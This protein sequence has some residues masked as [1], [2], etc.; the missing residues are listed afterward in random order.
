MNRPS[1]LGV[2]IAGV[3]RRA[4]HGNEPD[5]GSR[6]P[7]FLDQPMHA[8]RP[9]QIAPNESQRAPKATMRDAVAQ[10]RSS[11]YALSHRSRPEAPR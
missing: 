11:D 7:I 1:S 5:L 4:P 6:V 2:Q 3:P 10:S 8:L 9:K